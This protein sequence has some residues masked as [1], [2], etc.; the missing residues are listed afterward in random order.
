MARK[1]GPGLF[2]QFLEFM[3]MTWPGNKEPPSPAV[4]P[5]APLCSACHNPMHPVGPG[6][7]CPHHPTA[8]P[9]P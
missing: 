5:D 9:L 7:Q 8:S 4:P 2:W 3:G 6:W 1:D